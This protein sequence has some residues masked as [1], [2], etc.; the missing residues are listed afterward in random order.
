LRGTF[1]DIEKELLRLLPVVEEGGFVPHVDHRV[2]ADVPLENYKF[3]MKLKREMFR[4][5]K[6]EPMYEE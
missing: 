5:G 3:Y 2:P 6:K 4:A 1:K